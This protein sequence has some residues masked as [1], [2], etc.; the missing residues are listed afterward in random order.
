M[1]GLMMD[2][3]E[4]LTARLDEDAASAKTAIDVGEKRYGELYHEQVGFDPDGI[5]IDDGWLTLDAERMLREVDAKRKILALHEPNNVTGPGRACRWCGHL[6]PC[7]EIRA[8]VGVYGDHPDYDP[9]W[10]D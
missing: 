2:L 7:E 1:E 6:W 4:F 8:L 5:G 10:K 9:A 3:A